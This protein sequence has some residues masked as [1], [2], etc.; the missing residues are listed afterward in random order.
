MPSKIQGQLDSK[1]DILDILIVDDEPEIRRA[2]TDLL[3]EEGYKC[4]GVK[5]G[6]SA[7]KALEIYPHFSLILC[8]IQMPKVNGLQFLVKLKAQ[9]QDRHTLVFLTGNGDKARI[10]EALRLGAADFIDK[11]FVPTALLTT[12]QRMVEVGVRK[13]RL[14]ESRST[15]SSTVTEAKLVS[16]LQIVNSE[17]AKKAS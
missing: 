11:P 6:E 5:D 8:D 2:L 10:L 7:L 3:E 14:W 12:V 1:E 13:Q 16:L 9:Y 15:N 17:A 4:F